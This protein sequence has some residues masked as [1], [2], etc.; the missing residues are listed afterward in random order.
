[1]NKYDNMA[2]KQNKERFQ[3]TLPTQNTMNFAC[4]LSTSVSLFSNLVLPALQL[5]AVPNLNIL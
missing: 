5:T 4:C 2:G 3:R 1:M